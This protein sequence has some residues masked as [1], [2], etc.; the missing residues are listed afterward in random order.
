MS[1]IQVTGP[2]WNP[3]S[4]HYPHLRLLVR[5]RTYMTDWKSHTNGFDLWDSSAQVILTYNDPWLISM[6]YGFKWLHITIT[7]DY[8]KLLIIP[9]D[10]TRQ[11]I[12]YSTLEW[13]YSWT[14]VS[15]LLAP[16]IKYYIH[17]ISHW[18]HS[19]GISSAKHIIYPYNSIL[20]IWQCIRCDSI[21]QHDS[22]CLLSV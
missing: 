2:W 9:V 15:P 12:T 7:L 11:T 19:T 10:L 4:P 21:S 6:Q 5:P 20:I 16:R 8:F 3:W 13:Y 17:Y 1:F 18:T 22:A 14:H